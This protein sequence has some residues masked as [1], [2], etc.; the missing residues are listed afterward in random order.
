MV[1]FR[2]IIVNTLHTDDNN[3]MMMMMI[4]IIINPPFTLVFFPLV[5]AYYQEIIHRSES[6]KSPQF[7]RQ[8]LRQVLDFPSR[9]VGKYNVIKITV[10]HN[11]NYYPDNRV[12]LL[13]VFLL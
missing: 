5:S 12:S 3:M 4:I 6:C 10:K 11:L 8:L 7:K 1:L 2:Y 13:N 9:C